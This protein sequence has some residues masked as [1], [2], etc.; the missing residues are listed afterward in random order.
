[1]FALNQ[2]TRTKNT[3]QD[4]VRQPQKTQ[5]LLVVCCTAF[6]IKLHR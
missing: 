3:T 6:R 1:M 5:M 4:T 2:Q